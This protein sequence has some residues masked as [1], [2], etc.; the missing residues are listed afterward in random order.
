M[1]TYLFIFILGLLIGALA[2]TNEKNEEINRLTLALAAGD[3]IVREV[4]KTMTAFIERNKEAGILKYFTVDEL[5]AE[6]AT[7]PDEEYPC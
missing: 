1:I 3:A 5:M 6:L 7:R 4:Q 2:V